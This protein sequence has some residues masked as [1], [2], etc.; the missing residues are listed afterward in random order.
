MDAITES[1]IGGARRS[2]L[3]AFTHGATCERALDRG[4]KRVAVQ[5][6]ADAWEAYGGFSALAVRLPKRDRDEVYATAADGMTAVRLL[7]LLDTCRTRLSE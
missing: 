2:L 7:G 5:A 3:A 4:S 1:L 6:F